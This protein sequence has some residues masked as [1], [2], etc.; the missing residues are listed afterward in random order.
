VA[1]SSVTRLGD[2]LAGV[3]DVYGTIAANV[4]TLT[5]TEIAEVSEPTG[6]G[7]GTSS[8]MPQKRNPVYSV[9]L[10]S[11]SLRAPGLASTLHVAAASFVDERPD[12]AWHAEWPTIRELLRIVL[13]GAALLD[14]LTAGLT[15]DV[16]RAAENLAVTGDDI[17]AERKKLGGAAGIAADYVG[18]SSAFIDTAIARARS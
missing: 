2:A 6:E 8:A 1:R 15:V 5:R 18:L 11:L 10:R 12:G 14:D 3:A 16:D 4:A 17:L 13:G 7:R 9:L